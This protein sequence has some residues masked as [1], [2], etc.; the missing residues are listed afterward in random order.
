MKDTLLAKYSYINIRR[1]NIENTKWR[2]KMKKGVKLEIASQEDV[3]VDSVIVRLLPGKVIYNYKN[4]QLAHSYALCL[5]TFKF[6]RL[7]F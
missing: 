2:K 7:T 3:T 5:N 6:V 1:L 4:H